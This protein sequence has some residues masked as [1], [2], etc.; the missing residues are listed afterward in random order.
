MRDEVEPAPLKSAPAMLAL[1][2]AC[3]SASSSSW[4]LLLMP[5]LAE[6]DVEVREG[7]SPCD[8]IVD[9]PVPPATDAGGSVAAHSSAT[10]L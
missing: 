3:K 5:A 4:P 7:R 10:E 9:S 2:A 6:D 1:S 8:C